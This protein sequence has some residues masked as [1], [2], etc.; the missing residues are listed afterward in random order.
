MELKFEYFLFSIK[1]FLNYNTWVIQIKFFKQN[2][3]SQTT[4]LIFVI[5]NKD[6]EK[7][8]L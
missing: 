6:L 3:S 7:K 5:P 2:V 8:L 1:N 4:V